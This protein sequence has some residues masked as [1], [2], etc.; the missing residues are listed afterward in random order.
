MTTPLAV[1]ENDL[2]M[3]MA[4][5]D[6]TDVDDAGHGLPWSAMEALAGLVPGKWT[7]F[8]GIDVVNRRHYFGQGVGAGEHESEGPDEP[9]DDA[10][11]Y[12]YPDSICS[13]PER[14]SDFRSVTKT[15]D[16]YTLREHR[17]T[18]MYVDVTGPNDADHE[19]MACLPDGPG[20]QL[21]LI[22]WRGRAD[23]DFT[24]RDR[25]VLTLLRPHLQA[26]HLQV[27][28]HQRGIPALTDRQWEL[29]YL[30]D[31][32]LSNTQIARQLHVAESTVRKH[33]ENV[34][35]RL[36]VTSRTAA[37]AVVFPSRPIV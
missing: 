32:G 13:Y 35:R 19:M 30:V 9:E 18:P 15:T 3:M 6:A 36:G 4:V 8:N 25:A 2:R 34:F 29:L 10:F 1:S 20:R 24:E 31:A 28:R 22:V 23:P 5:V 12:H 7:T 27:L 14:A 21:R 37:V 11:W 16:F 33:L 17:A 26:I